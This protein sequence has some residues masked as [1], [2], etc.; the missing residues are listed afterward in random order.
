MKFSKDHEI[1]CVRGEEQ[2]R[3][4]EVRRFLYSRI[5][6]LEQRIEGTN[7]SYNSTS[8]LF[9]ELKA[10]LQLLSLYN[11]EFPPAPGELESL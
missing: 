6:H 10:L 9:Q 2:L 4:R 1:P 3:P 8:F 7:P 5:I 11:K